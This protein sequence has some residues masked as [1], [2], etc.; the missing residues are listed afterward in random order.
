METF[1]SAAL[2]KVILSERFKRVDMGL[3]KY[4][5]GLENCKV[6]MQSRFRKGATLNVRRDV[7]VCS[8]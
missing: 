6:P 1:E 5:L 2:F 4:L 3:C 8:G 7:L